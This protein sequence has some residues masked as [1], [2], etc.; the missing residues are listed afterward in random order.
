MTFP[1][2]PIT[3]P[4][5]AADAA[6]AIKLPSEVER[7]EALAASSPSVR[8]FIVTDEWRAIRGRIYGDGNPPLDAPKSLADVAFYLRWVADGA[9]SALKPGA[10]EAYLHAIAE[11]EAF[12]RNAGPAPIDELAARR[13]EA[14]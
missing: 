1:A 4:T 11:I 6:R 2:R 9:F 13:R 3:S 7:F 14:A 5:A 8:A 10:Q 12:E